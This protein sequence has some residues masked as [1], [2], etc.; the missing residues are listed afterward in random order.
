MSGLC[1]QRKSASCL[2]YERYC[3]YLIIKE[4][5]CCLYDSRV[6]LLYKYFMKNNECYTILDE[7]MGV[8]N[9]SG[10][11]F[12]KLVDRVVEDTLNFP[13]VGTGIKEEDVKEVKGN[14]D[15]DFN[16]H[17]VRRFTYNDTGLDWLPSLEVIWIKMD[18][19]EITFGGY[20]LNNRHAIVIILL[21]MFKKAHY[22]DTI[23]HEIRHLHTEYIENKHTPYKMSAAWRD[24]STSITQVETVLYSLS[25]N[26]NLLSKLNVELKYIDTPRTIEEAFVVI[27]KNMYFF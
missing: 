10:S 15:F 19:P 17:N 13:K 24:K 26:K 4:P 5:G 3:R 18:K 23:S 12:S 11:A 1:S 25:T 21:D 2:M 16:I 22:E 20:A 8:L 14:H 27:L 9:I 7:A 6:S